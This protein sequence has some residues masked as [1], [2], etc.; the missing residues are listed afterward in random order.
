MSV[1]SPSHSI[2]LIVAV[3]LARPSQ[4]SSRSHPSCHPFLYRL[5][6]SH[7]VPALHAS[8]TIA[9]WTTICGWAGLNMQFWWQ[10]NTPVFIVAIIFLS[11]K[12]AIATKNRGAILPPKTAYLTPLSHIWYWDWDWVSFLTAIEWVWGSRHMPLWHSRLWR[13]LQQLFS[14]L[15]SYTLPNTI[16]S[17]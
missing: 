17:I 10:N 12:N 15:H 8:R 9:G 2:P 4:D 6:Q 5:Y 7:R 16:D 11:N 13:L 14:L 1:P 3:R